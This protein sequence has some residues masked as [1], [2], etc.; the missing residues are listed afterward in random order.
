MDAPDR[1]HSTASATVGVRAVVDQG[2]AFSSIVHIN[3]KG[4]RFGGTEEYIDLITP[5]L[6]ARGVRSHLVCGTVVGDLPDTIDSTQTIAGLAERTP[7]TGVVDTVSAVIRSLDA[8]VIYLH[9]VFDPGIVH[10][11]AENEPQATLLWYVHDHYVTC[12]S[13]L[14]WRRDHGACEQRLGTGCLTAI[15]Q[16]HC[17]LRHR[18]RGLHP[19]DL[20]RRTALSASLGAA[21]AVVV[22]SGYMRRLLAD[23][24]PQLGERIR[25]VPRPIRNLGPP[26]A[27]TRAATDPAVVTFAGR[28]TPEK[29]LDILIN[30]LARSRSGGPIELRIAGTIENPAYWKHCDHLLR[31]AE[32]HNPLL[33]H[34]SL[35][36]LAY[37][38]IDALFRSS[39]IVAVPSQWPEPLGCVALEAMAAGAAVAASDIGGL[40]GSIRHADNGIL[41]VPAATEAW[42]AAIDRLVDQPDV[43]RRLGEHAARDSRRATAATHVETLDDIVKHV[44]MS[45]A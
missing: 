11:I 45:K 17:V 6:S 18:D 3:E 42:T 27:R 40:S 31:R 10:T 22:V 33:S 5:E 14:R 26:P 37:E 36:H 15:G 44:R 13:E 4:G 43:A 30:A 35:G 39:D 20:R 7:A 28:I 24:Q 1:Q 16:G 8:D 41:V 23:A 34:T 9:N 32:H 38:H 19:D 29:G 2:L 12:L 21:D 25:L